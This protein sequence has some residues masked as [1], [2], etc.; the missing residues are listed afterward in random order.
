[1]NNKNPLTAPSGIQADNRILTS[2]ESKRLFENARLVWPHRAHL[3]WAHLRV[4]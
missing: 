4:C 3:K 1:M 2:M